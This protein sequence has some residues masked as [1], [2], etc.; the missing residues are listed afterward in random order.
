MLISD[1]YKQLN[2]L[3]HA[4][5]LMYGTSGQAYANVARA[6]MDD[7]DTENVLDYG[8]GKCTLEKALGVPI[9]NYDPCL[10]GLDSVPGPHDIVICTDVLEH[11]EPECLRDVL[12]DLRRL[13]RKVA[14]LLIDTQPAKKHLADG[15]NAHLIL[16][17]MPWWKQKL[18]D[19]GF[20]IQQLEEQ[21]GK[22]IVVVR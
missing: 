13:T 21:S 22:V 6:M 7:Y 14:F 16:E 17:A 8:C 10:P 20:D 5:S 12:L 4:E 19:A 1:S 3:K 15:R 9:T 18:E 11:I 2:R